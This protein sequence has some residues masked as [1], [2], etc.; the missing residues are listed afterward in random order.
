MRTSTARKHGYTCPK[1]GDD[2]TQDLQGRGYVRH[3]TNRSCRY[4]NGMKDDP[5]RVKAHV[6][7]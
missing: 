4:E 2:T 6:R 5:R 1:C 3:K 7:T